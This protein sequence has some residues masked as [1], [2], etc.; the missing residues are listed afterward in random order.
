MKGQIRKYLTVEHI[1]SKV[2][3]YDIYRYYLGFDFSCGK[4]Y[5]SPFR[6]EKTPSFGIK[7][8]PDGGLVHKDFGAAEHNKG[9]CFDFV[10]QLYP[11]LSFHEALIKIDADMRLGILGIEG[12]KEIIRGYRKDVLKPKPKIITP[13][14]RPFTSY[15]LEYWKQYG[16]TKKDLER[17]YGDVTVHS[18]SSYK[19]G[20]IRVKSRDEELAFGYRFGNTHWKIY[21]P[22]EDFKWISTVPLDRAYGLENLDPHYPA[23]IAKSFKDF[24]TLLKIYPYVCGVQ[25]ES[26]EAFSEETI[27]IIRC[28]SKVAYYGG[29]CDEPGKKAS[30]EITE[31]LGFKHI[32]VPDEYLNKK[33]KDFAD[34]AKYEGLKKIEHY[35]KRKKIM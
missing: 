5:I 14:I 9:N 18:I 33:V 12:Y 26:L 30:W 17:S 10:M 6:N 16:H 19:I 29:D 1:L 4:A 11:G 32:N 7:I 27:N 35:L 34:W 22:Y 8:M 20:K 3:P 25:N 21:K 15:D 28:N 13:V 31:K 24:S 2:T 23:I